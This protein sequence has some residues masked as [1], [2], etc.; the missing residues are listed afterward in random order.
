M[1]HLAS[2]R[3]HTSGQVA[4]SCIQSSQQLIEVDTVLIF[5]NEGLRFQ[6]STEENKSRDGHRLFHSCLSFR[7]QWCSEVTQ[8]LSRSWKKENKGTGW[9][10]SLRPFR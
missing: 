2:S 7:G 3:H 8:R 9:Y 1:G 5:S 10:C 6:E 4:H